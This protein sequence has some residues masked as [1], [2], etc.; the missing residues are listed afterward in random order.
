MNKFATIKHL[1][2]FKKVS[3]YTLKIENEVSLYEAFYEK[4]NNQADLKEDLAIILQQINE[5]GDHIGAELRYFR[6]EG[7]A[8]ALPSKVLAFEG[9]K[10]ALRLYCAVLSC[11]VVFLFNG[12]V[13]TTMKAKDCPNVK[14]H[15]ELANKLSEKLTKAIIEREIWIDD[16]FEHRL[17][18]LN[19]FE[20][21]I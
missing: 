8:H 18:I 21:E 11:N 13:K 16:G 10:T 4:I 20:I 3:F 9:E 2:T 7:S 1:S 14:A 5:I 19:N 17:R 15:F 12:D 6:H